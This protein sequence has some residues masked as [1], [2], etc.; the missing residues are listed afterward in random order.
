MVPCDGVPAK[1]RALR[2]QVAA[3]LITMVVTIAVGTVVWGRFSLALWNASRE[4][5]QS[6]SY[7]PLPEDRRATV[8]TIKMYAFCGY[9]ADSA[10]MSTQ[11]LIVEGAETQPPL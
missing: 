9:R 11:H 4:K 6:V 2:A 10:E 5:H 8:R 3:A 1:A 7:R